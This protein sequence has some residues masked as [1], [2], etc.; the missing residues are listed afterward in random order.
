MVTSG[1]PRCPFCGA[2]L[3]WGA[4][5][6]P[7]CGRSLVPR[8]A[9]LSGLIEGPFPRRLGLERHGFVRTCYNLFDGS[10][11]LGTFS[12]RWPA[13]VKFR[14]A[15]GHLYRTRRR[16]VLRLGLL[17]T[18]GVD[19]VASVEQC[20][21]WVRQYLLEYGGVQYRLTSVSPMSLSFYLRDPEDRVLA[22]IDS[23]FFRRSPEVTVHASVP[24]EVMALACATALV[25][26]RQAVT[27]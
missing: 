19:L 2:D 22:E 11:L 13:G 8:Q 25:L 21:P 15:R 5:V 14:S 4:L 3:A 1:A 6:C 26:W 17:W 10:T 20:R 27:A 9:A 24:L 12:Q 7:Y 18:C 16:R 23:A